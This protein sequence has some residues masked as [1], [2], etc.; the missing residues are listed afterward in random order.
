M[1]SRFEHKLKQNILPFFDV[2]RVGLLLNLIGTILI[3]KSTDFFYSNATLNG[4]GDEAH[5]FV[6]GTHPTYLVWGSYFIAAG[7]VLP[8]FKKLT[9]IQTFVTFLFFFIVMWIL[10][11]LIR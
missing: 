1:K 10:D 9:V 11:L 6:I 5:P 2:D 8:F 4:M 3:T 7:F